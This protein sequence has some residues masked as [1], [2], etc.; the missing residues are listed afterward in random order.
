MKEAKK[1]NA[2][3]VVFISTYTTITYYLKVFLE[4]KERQQSSVQIAIL[5]FMNIVRN[6]LLIRMMRKRLGRFG[7]N[8]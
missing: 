4:K 5:I 3:N 7:M 6:K 8:G 1:A 2:R